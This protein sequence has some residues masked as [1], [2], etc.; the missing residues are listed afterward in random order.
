MQLRP[1]LFFSG[2]WEEALT[3]YQHCGL[4]QISGV[5]RY[6]GSPMAEAA[7]PG[8]GHKIMYAGFA[9]PG[10]AFYTS[11]NFQA[12]AMSGFA[13][14]LNVDDLAEA[15]RLVT[16]LAEGGTLTLPFAQQFWGGH[17]GCL[18]DRFGVAW[19]I[20]REVA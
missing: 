7:G 8:N 4:G 3:F 15:E 5:M 13:L 17:L 10:L 16:A 14:S 2:S 11:D 19:M 1:Y 18:N 12:G 9:G 20:S 6:E